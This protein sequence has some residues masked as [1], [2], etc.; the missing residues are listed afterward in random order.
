MA[1]ECKVDM[2]AI[3][4]K[5]N[6]LRRDSMRLEATQFH[7]VGRRPESTDK[8]LLVRILGH[9]ELSLFNSYNVAGW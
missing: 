6:E 4:H 9:Q 3:E 2:K 7:G 1:E 5:M 8:L